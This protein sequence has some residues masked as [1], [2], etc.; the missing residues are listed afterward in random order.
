MTLVANFDNV[1]KQIR[2]Y[3]KLLYN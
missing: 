1:M 2:K 3:R